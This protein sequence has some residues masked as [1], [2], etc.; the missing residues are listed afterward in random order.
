MAEKSDFLCRGLREKPPTYAEC[1]DFGKRVLAEW[2]L[3]ELERIN[4]TLTGAERKAALCMLLDQETQLLAAIDRHKLE[5]GVDN[6]Q[7]RI[8][9]FLEKASFFLPSTHRPP[10]FVCCLC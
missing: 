6:K 4:S 5:T 10:L 9:D 1:A 3:E 7:Q 2:R 8:Q